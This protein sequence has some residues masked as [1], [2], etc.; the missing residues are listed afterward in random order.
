MGDPAEQ[1]GPS[2]RGS[3]LF[4]TQL[5]LS[6]S[7]PA[8]SHCPCGHCASIPKL[9]LLCCLISFCLLGVQFMVG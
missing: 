6:T 5:S 4:S 9:L 3:G 1:A 8:Y 7:A 2:G